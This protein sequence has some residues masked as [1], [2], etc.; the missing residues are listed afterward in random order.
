MSSQ[1]GPA[2]VP[3]PEPPKEIPEL[4]DAYRKAHKSYVLASGLLASW[5]LIGITI[6]TKEKW[7]I[8]LKSPAAV[9]LILFTLVIY[10]GYKTTIEWWQCNPD[11]KK[12]PAAKW[13]YRI[14]HTIASAAIV[15]SFIQYLLHIQIVDVLVH[16]RLRTLIVTVF[17][18][19]GLATAALGKIRSHGD[20]RVS[21]IALGSIL[22][23]APVLS[24]LVDGL[25]TRNVKTIASTCAAL[26]LA[27]AGYV[28]ALR[29][30]RNNEYRR[31]Q[32]PITPAAKEE[33][34]P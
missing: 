9:P 13:D 29:R 1:P 27:T 7:G 24:L 32:V 5:E 8:E 16:H 12:H 23:L 4:T 15:I 33:S 2:L 21:L 18:G 19:A 34:T 14:A 22:T 26:G 25:I 11:R 20:L 3:Q 30:Q 17:I 31:L 28:Y 6:Q 10:S